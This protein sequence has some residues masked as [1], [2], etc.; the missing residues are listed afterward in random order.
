MAY[1][2]KCGMETVPDLRFCN[3]CGADQSPQ[4]LNIESD[5]RSNNSSMNPPITNY[6]QS[7]PAQGN[8]VVYEASMPM[9]SSVNPSY[10]VAGNQ[11]THQTGVSGNMMNEQSNS[12]YGERTIER[13]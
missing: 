8:P 11:V 13:A 7:Y 4:N 12:T 10:P 9:P 3:N 1:C 5:L 6:P 2:A